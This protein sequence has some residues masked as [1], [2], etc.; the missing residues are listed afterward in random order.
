MVASRSRCRDRF[1]SRKRT[2]SQHPVM[3]RFQPVPTHSEKVLNDAV[4]RQ[5]ALRLASGGKKHDVRAGFGTGMEERQRTISTLGQSRTD[6]ISRSLSGI[7]PS[8]QESTTY[9]PSL[10]CKLLILGCRL[11]IPDRLLAMQTHFYPDFQVDSEGLPTSRDL[12][13]EIPPKL[14]LLD[15]SHCA[16]LRPRR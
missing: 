15:V 1:P 14:Q 12:R 9:E 2:R 7:A 8:K 5:E 3:N 6:K 10:V 13:R 16:L 11:L 4:N